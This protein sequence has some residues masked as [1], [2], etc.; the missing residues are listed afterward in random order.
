MSMTT[1]K[2]QALDSLIMTCEKS[3]GKGTIQY[4]ERPI[5]KIPLVCSTGS[6]KLDT[7]LGVGGIPRGRVIEIYGGESA[8]KTTLTLSIIAEAQKAGCVCAF[9][10]AE[11]A[12]D[13]VW[14]N[15]LK[16]NTNN[17]LISQPDCGEDALSIVENCVDSGVVDLVIVDSVACLTPKAEID[18][19]MGDSH[20][21]L[22]ARLMSQA[23]RKLTGKIS[24]SKCTVIFINQ[25]RHKI[26]V[27]FGS[28][29]TTTGG[30]ALKF[31]ASIRMEMRNDADKDINEEFG[32]RSKSVK[33][34]I[35]KNKVAPPFKVANV[36]LN[37]NEEKRIYGFNNYVEVIELGSDFEILKKSGTWYSYKDEKLGQGKDNVSDFLRNN[38]SMYEEI[39]KQVVDRLSSSNLDEV[40]SFS[41]AITEAVE[42]NTKAK[43][44]RGE[45]SVDIKAEEVI[46][47]EVV[48]D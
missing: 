35:V 38:P 17:V 14:A 10:D 2:Q 21:G 5:E 18:G 19:E 25:I 40:G 7:A 37:T 8:G 28:P 26:G 34:K 39:K 46:E 15:K 12:L 42:N 9:I 31:Y 44:R 20:M 22:Q 47:A 4:G 48:E 3:F 1:E 13:R 30:N 36:S 33:I 45:T 24:K 11:H 6:L 29:E 23:L 27:M 43:K 32:Q 41:S 16:V